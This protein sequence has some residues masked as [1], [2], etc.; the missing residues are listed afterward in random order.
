[1]IN[2]SKLTEFGEYNQ[3]MIEAVSEQWNILNA[4]MSFASA[5]IKTM[6]ALEF[7]LDK[8]GYVNDLQVQ[9]S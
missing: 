5:E 3:R 7:V 4:R 1:M 9:R 6:V 2:D 8:N